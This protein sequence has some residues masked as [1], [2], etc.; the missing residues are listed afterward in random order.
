M[1]TTITDLTLTT[2]PEA[3]ATRA[4]ARARRFLCGKAVRGL[5]RGQAVHV[6]CQRD[7]GHEGPCGATSIESTPPVG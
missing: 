3:P 6:D 4:A 5:L 7:P 1:T 2:S